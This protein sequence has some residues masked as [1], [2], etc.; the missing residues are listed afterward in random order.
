MDLTVVPTNCNSFYRCTLGQ[1]GTLSCP[2]GIL[3]L[4]Y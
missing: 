1:L 4:N 2:A 3:N